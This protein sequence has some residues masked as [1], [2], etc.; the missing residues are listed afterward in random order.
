M[1]IKVQDV[2]ID[3]NQVYYKI[4][5][6]IKKAITS[7]KQGETGFKANISGSYFNALDTI[8]D[9]FKMLEDAINSTKV[10]TKE[11]KYLQIGINADC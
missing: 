6:A 8:N 11:R 7:H 1:N 5:T 9:S 10:N 4:S 3:A 2:A